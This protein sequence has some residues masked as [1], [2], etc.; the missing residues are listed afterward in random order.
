MNSGLLKA[1]SAA[2]QFRRLL[3]QFQEGFE[4]GHKMKSWHIHSY[5]DALQLGDT[6]IPLIE[7][8]DD[9]LVKV[10]A[11]SVNPIDA[12]MLGKEMG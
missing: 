2:R 1:R 11:A 6:R 4:R 3:T 8:P 5:G 12:V 7:N 9:V 10:D